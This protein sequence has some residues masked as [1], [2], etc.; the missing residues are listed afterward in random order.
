MF[1]RKVSIIGLFPLKKDFLR[2]KVVHQINI[3]NENSQKK[4]RRERSFL[5]KLEAVIP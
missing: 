2:G 5:G 1:L 4:V 3:P